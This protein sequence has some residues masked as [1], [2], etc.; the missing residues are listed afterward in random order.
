MEDLEQTIDAKD[1]EL[2]HHRQPEVLLL[3]AAL[4]Q[5]SGLLLETEAPVMTPNGVDFLFFSIAI[6][7]QSLVAVS[8]PSQNCKCA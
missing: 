6:V 3:I 1:N 7:C 2:T 4:E 8:K 5:Q